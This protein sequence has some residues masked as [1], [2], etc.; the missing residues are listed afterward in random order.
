MPRRPASG[1]MI[2]LFASV[3][4]ATAL[5]LAG[6]GTPILGQATSPPTT[7]PPAAEPVDAVPTPR[8]DATCDDLLS[9]PALQEFVGEG[10][11]PLE[12][13]DESAR[14][15]PDGLALRQLGSLECVWTT[16]PGPLPLYNDAPNS[17]RR[18]I[19]TVLPEGP[20]AAQRYVDEYSVVS[21]PSDYGP[22]I[23]GPACRGLA[24]QVAGGTAACD[25]QGWVGE[26]WVDLLLTGVV[27]R[28][29][30]T[31]ASLAERFR[32]V[33][34]PLVAAMSAA[35]PSRERWNPPTSSG[36]AGR[37][38]ADVAPT[39][40]IIAV[41]G[42]TGLDVDERW[43]GP[44]V[45]QTTYAADEVGSVRCW[46]AFAGSDAAVGSVHV[47]PSGAWAFDELRDDW[48]A[49]GAVPV[50]FAGFPGGSAL[51]QC[52]DPA[53]RCR[54][55][56]VVDGDWMQVSILP[57]PP[58]TGPDA[59]PSPAEFAAARTSVEAIAG[60]VAERLATTG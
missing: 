19:L 13:V 34:D 60:V 57:P 14:S 53:D 41:T 4:V 24:P 23:L 40:S 43:D 28:P 36:N 15:T 55:D 3:V 32:A 39:E 59:Y 51:R 9:T 26:A 47:L 37:T 54:V 44:R 45:G 12:L 21:G 56:V 20:E 17:E 7:A 25:L 2:S 50:E 48:I 35:P 30:D 38:C 5:T 52:D 22:G 42:I 16:A 27:A 33:T 29:G 31:D 6:C 58:G 1:L 46:I 10:T 8:V 49:A 18:V 11:R